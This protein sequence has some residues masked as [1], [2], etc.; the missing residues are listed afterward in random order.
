VTAPVLL[1]LAGRLGIDLPITE[2]VCRI[3]EGAPSRDLVASL[4]GRP[5]T[6]E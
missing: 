3:L 5:P 1:T 2:S 6:T 4:M